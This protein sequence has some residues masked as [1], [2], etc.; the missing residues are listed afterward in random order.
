MAV[1]ASA[2]QLALAESRNTQRGL[3][4]IA[5][6]PHHRITASPHH[7]NDSSLRTGNAYGNHSADAQTAQLQHRSCGLA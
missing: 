2:R 4:L 3:A 6:S 5:A 1:L 7:R